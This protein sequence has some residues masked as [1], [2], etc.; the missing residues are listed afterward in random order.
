M[1]VDDFMDS[2]NVTGFFICTVLTLIV[3]LELIKQIL[4]KEYYR[5]KYE[6]TNNM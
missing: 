4:L 3:V 5:I 2:R 6:R 1:K